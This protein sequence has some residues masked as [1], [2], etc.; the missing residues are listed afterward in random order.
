MR[1]NQP[2]LAAS[3]NGERDDGC[4]KRTG[5]G[6][7][8]RGWK[9]AGFS[10]CAA[11]KLFLAVG[12][13][14]RL[15]AGLDFFTRSSS[16]KNAFFAASVLSVALAGVSAQAHA[17]TYAIDPSHTFVTFEMP[18]FATSTNRGRFDKKEG[19][20]DYDVAAKTGKVTL[21]LDVAS[22]NTGTE[23]FNKH[24][25][26][27]D[28][29]D[30]DKYPTAKFVGDKFTFSGDKV[31]EVNGQLTLKGKTNAV[32]LK[33]TRFNCY[34]NPMLKR[35][36]CGGDFKATIKR[37]QW[38]IDYGMNYGFPDDVDL[39]IQVEAIKQE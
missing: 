15:N 8:Y 28:F 27:A 36:A 30:T 37:S 5:G 20:V 11:A 33:A 17:A 26:G 24:L 16:M 25:K 10:A 18:H 23:A 19:T 6:P 12:H 9:C 1:L 14:L 31:T 34:Q 38:G 21:T 32:T 4:P 13:R 35:E 29:F 7:L 3:A 22:I 2:Q 39:I